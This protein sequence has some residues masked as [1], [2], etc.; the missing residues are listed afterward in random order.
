MESEAASAVARRTA[1]GLGARSGAAI[2]D[3]LVA[4]AIVLMASWTWMFATGAPVTGREQTAPGYVSAGIDIL[5]GLYLTVTV[6]RGGT[7]GMR[8]AGLRVCRAWDATPPGPARAGARSLVLLAAVWLLALVHPALVA[9][10]V[11]LALALPAGRLP[12]DMV[13]GTAVV[14]AASSTTP[15]AGPH[16]STVHPDLDPAEARVVLTD[17][18]PCDVAPPRTFTG[19][20]YH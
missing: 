15:Q 3:A 13:T 20:R 10:Y 19:H 14:R 5:V 1:A 4:Y 18:G 12:H 6:A 8:A 2:L 7:W 16:A 9:A 17:L 11:L